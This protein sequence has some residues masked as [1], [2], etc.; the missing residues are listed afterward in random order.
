MLKPYRIDMPEFCAQV[1]PE[2]EAR[3]IQKFYRCR[4]TE[5]RLCAIA[6]HGQYQQIKYLSRAEFD[7]HMRSLGAEITIKSLEDFS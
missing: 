5:L 1:V 3:R 2:D 6:R 4:I 7:Y